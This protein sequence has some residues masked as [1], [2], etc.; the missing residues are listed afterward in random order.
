MTEKDWDEVWLSEGFATYFTLLFTEHNAGRDA[1][2]AG[3]RSQPDA[4]AR[5]GEAL[6][7]IAVVHD[8]LADMR[9]V[10][11]P[12]VYQKGGWVL[13][14]LR[15]TIGTDTF[16]RGIREYYRR[17]RDGSATSDDLRRVME[18]ASKQDLKWFFDQWLRRPISPSFDGSWRYDAAAKADSH[19]ARADADRVTPI[20]SRSNSVWAPAPA[21]RPAS[22]GST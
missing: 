17:Y 7:G 18:D 1:F 5:G 2:V 19:R 21:S 4:R 8:N 14:M 9:K 20:A 3:L 16:W 12:L 22:S 11:N 15:G 10:L 6:P 13:H